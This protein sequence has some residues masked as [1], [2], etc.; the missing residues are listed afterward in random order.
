MR[1]FKYVGPYDEVE[2]PALGVVVAHGE[3]VEVDDTDIADGL[4]GQDTWKHI[5]D[6][7]RSRA[8]KKATAKKATDPA[9]QDEPQTD[10]SASADDSQEG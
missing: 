1:R 5:P 6:P 8:A 7:K 2:V 3:T 9:P 4:E 10:P